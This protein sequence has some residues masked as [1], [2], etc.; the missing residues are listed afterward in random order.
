MQ[1]AGSARTL[2]ALQG[3]LCAEQDEQT[4]G[5]A[6]NGAAQPPIAVRNGFGREQP[7]TQ[8]YQPTEIATIST[9]DATPS[10]SEGCAGK[11]TAKTLA[12]ES[13]ERGLARLV[14][15]PIQKARQVENP[16]GST[17]N[18]PAASLRLSASTINLRPE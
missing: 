7:T 18:A 1:R 12:T 16:L 9:T 14:A 11:A 6:I 10:V 15:R 17:A 4:A 2:P 8:A 13:A 3:E 5:K